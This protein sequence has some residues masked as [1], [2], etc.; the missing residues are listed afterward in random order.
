MKILKSEEGYRD[1]LTSFERFSAEIRTF[2]QTSII[3]VSLQA[4]RI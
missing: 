2:Y 3:L 4:V 1:N